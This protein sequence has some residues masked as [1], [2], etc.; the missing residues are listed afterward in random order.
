MMAGVMPPLPPVGAEGSAGTA[1]G[2]GAEAGPLAN[3]VDIWV[4]SRDKGATTTAAATT[5]RDQ[6]RRDPN[7]PAKAPRGR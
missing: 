7:K 3:G 5:A 2:A 4:R 1:A 6:P